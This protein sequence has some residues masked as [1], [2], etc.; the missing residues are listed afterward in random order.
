VKLSK[1]S[2]PAANVT[3]SKQARI[4]AINLSLLFY[5][6]KII[7]RKNIVAQNI[8]NTAINFEYSPKYFTANSARCSFGKETY[9]HI[10]HKNNITN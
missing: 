3:K 6:L 7:D 10:I 5:I 9:Q 2:L 1:A 4:Y 8:I